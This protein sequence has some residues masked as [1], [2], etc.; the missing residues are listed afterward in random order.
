MKNIDPTGILQLV[1]ICES[2]PASDALADGEGEHRAYPCVTENRE[3]RE[4][5]RVD[6]LASGSG[7]ENTGR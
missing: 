3:R 4:L 6:A 1:I 7:A 5:M 2:E